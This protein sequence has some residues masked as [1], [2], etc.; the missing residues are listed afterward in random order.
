ML[1]IN[2]FWKSILM[3]ILAIICSFKIEYCFHIVYQWPCITRSLVL[4]VCFVDRCLSIYDSDCPFYIYKLFLLINIYSNESGIKHH[5]HSPLNDSWG[6][7]YFL[8]KLIFTTSMSSRLNI[9]CIMSKIRACFITTV[10]AGY[11]WYLTFYSQVEITCMT[12]SFHKERGE[13]FKA[14]K[15]TLAPPCFYWSACIKPAKWAIMNVCLKGIDFDPVSSIFRM[16]FGTVP[17]VW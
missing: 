17:K 10:F 16:D 3:M 13:G 2:T 15:I 4:C 14:H 1:D 9:S 12:A 5:N 6:H 11:M 8:I 7:W